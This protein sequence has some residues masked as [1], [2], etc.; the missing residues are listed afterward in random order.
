M[1]I[2]SSPNLL[3]VSCI[4]KHYTINE[5]IICIT[6]Y[7]YLVDTP[8]PS[9]AFFFEWLERAENSLKP[10]QDLFVKNKIA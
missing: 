9:S 10:Y 4:L 8:L 1:E 2:L 6:F 3:V 7:Y 5:L